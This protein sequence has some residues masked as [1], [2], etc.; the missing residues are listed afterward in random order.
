MNKEQTNKLQYLLKSLDD[1]DLLHA[2]NQL[3]MEYDSRKERQSL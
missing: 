1:I 2:I 3:K